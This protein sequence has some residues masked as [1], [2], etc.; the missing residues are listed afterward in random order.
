MEMYY[1]QYVVQTEREIEK[2]RLPM[3]DI[4]VLSSILPYGFVKN[5][6]GLLHMCSPTSPSEYDQTVRTCCKVFDEL[7]AVRDGL[8]LVRIRRKRDVCD[9]KTRECFQEQL[10]AMTESLNKF[11]QKSA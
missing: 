9:L 3:S 11:I 7:A 1:S 6:I 8:L 5:V 4:A 10:N 2:P